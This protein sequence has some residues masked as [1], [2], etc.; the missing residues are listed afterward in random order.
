MQVRAS[1][2]TKFYENLCQNHEFFSFCSYT[3]MVH[4]RNYIDL[5]IT[6][7]RPTARVFFN[8][9]DSQN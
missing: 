3:C 2:Y 9:I 5:I 1:T 7:G 8:V 4:V 6:V